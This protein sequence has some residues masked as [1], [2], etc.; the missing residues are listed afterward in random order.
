MLEDAIRHEDIVYEHLA[1][2]QGV[3]IPTYYGLYVMTKGLVKMFVMVLEELDRLLSDEEE[4]RDLK[5][6]EK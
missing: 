6:D 4:L 5:P 1:A 2:L 3:H